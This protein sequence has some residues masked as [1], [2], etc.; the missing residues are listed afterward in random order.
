MGTI[1]IGA[2]LHLRHGARRRRPSPARLARMAPLDARP[3][4]RSN[5]AGGTRFGARN[6]REPLAG[7]A[8]VDVAGETSRV[9]DVWVPPGSGVI[10]A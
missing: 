1:A 7:A 5:A 8:P 9:A 3:S 10:R 6:R 4:P 2:E